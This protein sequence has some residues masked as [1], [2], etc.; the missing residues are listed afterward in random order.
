MLDHVNPV[1]IRDAVPGDARMLAELMAIAG[2]GIP[3]WLWSSQAAPGEAPIDVGTRRAMR[4][5]GG[6]SWRNA[7]VAER[8][9]AV[10]GMILGYPLEADET[11]LA[12]IDPLLRP[13]IVLE[14]LVPGSWYI[15]AFAVFAPWRSTGIGARLI[16]AARDRTRALGLAR[17]S[18]QYFSENPRAGAFYAR[19]G[20]VETASKALP[21]N[22][23]CTYRGDT[24]LMVAQIPARD[25]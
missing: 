5:E 2:A 25:G 23:V 17:M 16:D 20:F 21:D 3:Q 8:E 18:V 19:H 6:F 4:E 15:N 11:D 12:E 9:G 1:L 7:I 13:F 22:D 10:V 14:R 24:V